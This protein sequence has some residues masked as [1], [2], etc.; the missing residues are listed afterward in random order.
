MN[1]FKEVTKDLLDNFVVDPE[2]VKNVDEYLVIKN[3]KKQI[4][5]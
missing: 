3:L 5:G 1:D 2:K 4:L